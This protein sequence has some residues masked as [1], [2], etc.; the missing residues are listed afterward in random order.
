[1]CS[2]SSHHIC[3]FVKQCLVI[4][5]WEQMASGDLSL[6]G[7]ESLLC[8]APV[9]SVSAGQRASWLSHPDPCNMAA[10]E[11]YCKERGRH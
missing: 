7:L 9:S 11:R 3:V 2:S 8:E 5:Q 6:T 10:S 1:M 4:F